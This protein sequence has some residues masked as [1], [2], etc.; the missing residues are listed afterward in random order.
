MGREGTDHPECFAAVAEWRGNCFVSSSMGVR[1]LLAAPN[2][3][4]MDEQCRKQHC[5][6]CGGHDDEWKDFDGGTLCQ[7]CMREI[8]AVLYRL[9]ASGRRCTGVKWLLVE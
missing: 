2:E 9:H 6:Q 5:A 4:A 1:F 3:D 7:K 8:E